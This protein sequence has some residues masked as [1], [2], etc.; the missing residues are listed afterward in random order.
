LVSTADSMIRLRS[1]VSSPIRRPG[2]KA[3]IGP[4]STVSDA[5]TGS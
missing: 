5:P 2:T 4:V 3:S 1:L